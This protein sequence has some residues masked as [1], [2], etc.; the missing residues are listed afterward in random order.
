LNLIDSNILIYSSL[1]HYKYLRDLVISDISYFSEISKLEVL[2]YHRI[3]DPEIEYFIRVFSIAHVFQLSAEL[4]KLPTP[5]RR[6]HNLSLA[7]SITCSTCLLFNLKVVTRNIKYFKKITGL[8][9][10][11]PT[12]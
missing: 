7:G 4:I 5:I 2:C 6:K 1:E 3:T 10:E 8:K 12:I 9:T 11:N